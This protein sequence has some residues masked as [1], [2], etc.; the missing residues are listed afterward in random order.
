MNRQVRGYALGAVLLLVSGCAQKVLVPPRVD[1]DSYP[2]LGIVTFTS[3]ARGNLEE[4]AT[5]KFMQAVQ[6]AQPGVRILELGGEERVLGAIEREELDFEAIQAIGDKW[7]VDAVF[8]GHLDVQDVKP[9]LELRSLLKEL[10]FDAHVQA[11]L[12]T[13]LVETQSGATVW[14]RSASRRA[15]VAHVKV[16]SSGPVDFGASD[17]E[18]AYGKL[19]YALVNGVTDDFYSR[20]E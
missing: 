12:N 3:N 9:N 6:H 16:V 4:H 8:S 2:T 7:G 17:P 18:E 1:L 11:G 13:R 20:W 14:T 10:S 19:V 15:P 5:R